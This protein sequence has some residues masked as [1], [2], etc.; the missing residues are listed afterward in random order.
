VKI[1]PTNVVSVPVCSDFQK[2]R[3]CE[4][5]VLKDYEGEMEYHLYSDDGGEWEEDD[6]DDYDDYDEESPVDLSQYENLKDNDFKD[7]W[8][9]N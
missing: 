9:N 7:N 3:T 1:N 6:W 4:Y 8:M 5:L 2:L